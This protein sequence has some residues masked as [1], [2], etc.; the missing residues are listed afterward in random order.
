MYGLT[1]YARV[2]LTTGSS[3][4]PPDLRRQ[5]DAE[6]EVY[7]VDRLANV[8]HLVRSGVVVRGSIS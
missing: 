4:S 1:E 2:V 7:I 6:H 5:S 8:Y 3:G